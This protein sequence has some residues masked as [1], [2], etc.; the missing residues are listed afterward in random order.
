[1]YFVHVDQYSLVNMENLYFFGKSMHV[2]YFF[3]N[4][5]VLCVLILNMDEHRQNAEFFV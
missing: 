5:M 4:S 2:Q 1:M 3:V